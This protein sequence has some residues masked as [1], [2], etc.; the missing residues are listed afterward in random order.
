MAQKHTLKAETRD[1]FGKNEM[2]RLRSTGRIPA[3][4]YGPGMDTVSVSVDNRELS[5]LLS[6]INFENTLI[7]LQLTGKTKKKY[8]ILIRELQRHPYRQQIQ[9]LDFY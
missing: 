7:D 3:S 4:L 8:R 6:Q 9:H 5:H 2:R 1:S